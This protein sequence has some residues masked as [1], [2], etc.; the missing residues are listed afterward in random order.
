MKIKVFALCSAVLLSC[1]SYDV[2]AQGLLGKLKKIG[3]N[4]VDGAKNKVVNKATGTVNRTAD[5]VV[6]DATGGVVSTSPVR[7]NGKGKKQ[8]SRDKQLNDYATAVL[9]P[10]GN[11]NMKDESPTVRLPEK[12]TAF[13]APL[14]YDV[15]KTEGVLS[16]KP[17]MPPVNARDQVEWV[18]K[19][20]LFELDNE[21]LIA[22]LL[23]LE[24]AVKDGE[25]DFDLSPA[26]H[27][28]HNVRSVVYD[29]RDAIEN[30]IKGIAEARSEYTMT[31]TYNW[32]I[33]G[34]HDDIVRTLESGPY[35]Q[36][37]RSSIMPFFKANLFLDLDEVTAYF[38]AHGGAE[39]A[40]KQK[41]THWDPNP[42]KKEVRTST[43]QKAVVRSDAGDSG[44]TID[45]GGVYYI[46]HTSYGQAF[47]KE[48]VKT[49]VKGQDIVIPE[50]VEH[51]GRMYPVTEV[52]AS[53]F[54]GSG[55][56]SVKLPN[57]IKEIGNKAFRGTDIREIVI[58]ASVKTVRGSAFQQCQYLTKVVFQATEMDEIQGCFAM[59]TRL[60]SVQMP[61][62]LKK[63][64]SYDMFRD[65]P[66]LTN[67]VLPKNL[68]YI[69]DNTFSGCKMLTKLNLPT[70]ITKIGH[71]AFDGCGLTSLYLPNLTDI[72]DGA[73]SDFKSLKSIT[74]SKTLLEKLK[75]DNYWLF[76]TNFGDNPNF[77]PKVNGNDIILPANIKTE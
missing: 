69:P 38:N 76:V 74:I 13:L 41:W 36:V 46:I 30:L 33:N 67:V 18:G 65:C 55:I 48:A 16:R 34:C 49:A 12:H 77:T 23:L 64:M 40:H 58:P 71:G 15:D 19:Q 72:D 7:V 56:R 59:C 9:G 43:G 21:S 45:I 20:P 24:K 10:D 5:K 28:W 39:N 61:A 51:N 70:T 62:S 63:D 66:A 35:K 68:R 57:T 73:F 29:R 22:E 4:V 50:K 2:Q 52:C 54:E 47:V 11:Q 8:S 42:N 14:S 3:K 60:Q 32:V 27:Y 1:G 44:S 53:A 26:W 6:N 31:D 37:I 25:V 17:V 75:A